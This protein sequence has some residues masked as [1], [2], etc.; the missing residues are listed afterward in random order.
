MLS[1]DFSRQLGKLSLSGDAV[2][3]KTTPASSGSA[4][5]RAV[6]NNSGPLLMSPGGTLQASN[7][8]TKS[9]V[10]INP[11]TKGI[12]EEDDD[13]EDLV[14]PESE[15][16]TIISS[17]CI[18]HAYVFRIAYC[19]IDALEFGVSIQRHLKLT[20]ISSVGQ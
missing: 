20:A 4:S 16:I 17:A 14:W 9:S 6:V 5:G 3:P 19:S 13:T 12:E 8:N 18:I 2:R 1:D 7:S 10:K 15:F 11:S